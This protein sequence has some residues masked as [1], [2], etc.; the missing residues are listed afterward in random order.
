MR[1]HRIAIA[2]AL[3]AA[4][5]GFQALGAVALPAE[6]GSADAGQVAGRAAFAYLGGLRTFAAAVLWNRLDPQF[7]EYYAPKGGSIAEHVYM[8]PTLAAVQ[9]LDPQ[10]V[11]AYYISSYI[12]AK[13]E[14]YPAGIAIAREGVRNNPRSGLMRSNLAQLL[15]LDDPKKHE[16]EMIEQAKVALSQQAQWRDEDEAFEGYVVFRDVMRSAGKDKVA[17]ELDK[18]IVALKSQGAGKGDHDHNG[19]GK[20]DH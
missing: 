20:Q 2:A 12:V 10:F 7:H 9:A 6:S 11:Q 14:G 3:V 4:V 19:D 17:G 5:L 18:L 15:L 16:A 8:V 1:G 13:Q